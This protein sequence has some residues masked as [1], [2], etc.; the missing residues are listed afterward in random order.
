MVTNG[1]YVDFQ[2]AFD[3]VSHPKLLSKIKAYN[4]LDDSFEWIRAF[5]SGRTQ[6]VKIKNTLS[7]SIFVTSGVPPGQLPWPYPFSTVHK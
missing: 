2:K 1:V 7:H 6:Q 3:T 4:I 5:L